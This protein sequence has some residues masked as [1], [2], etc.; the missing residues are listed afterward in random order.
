MTGKLLVAHPSLL[1]DQSFGRSVVLMAEHTDEGSLGFIVNQHT[2]YT[3]RDLVPE[4]ELDAPVFQGGPVD[5]DR[6]FYVHT[7]AT[8]PHAKS[9]GNHLFWGGDLEDIK[10]AIHSKKLPINQ[11]KFLLGYAGW[12]EGQLNAEC[13]TNAWL[14]VKNSY[15]VFANEEHLWGTILRDLGGELAYYAAAPTHPGLN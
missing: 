6:L 7:L 1:G 5:L 10:A 9:L 11:I 15:N 8:I 3:L 14:L 13:K 2:H 12:S 4:L